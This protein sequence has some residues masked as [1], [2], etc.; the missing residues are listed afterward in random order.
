[1]ADQPTRVTV[2]SAVTTA[3]VTSA[4][5]LL[6]AAAAI[7]AFADD[8]GNGHTN[9]GHTNNGKHYGQTKDDSSDQSNGQTNGQSKGQAKGQS[10]GHAKGQST[11]NG[12]G[13]SG[14]NASANASSQNSTA[15]DDPAGNNGTVKI[16]DVYG[17]TAHHNVPHV[18]CDFAVAF[19]GFDAGQQ[20]DVS[21]AGQA[22][23]GKD[24]PLTVTGASTSIT[25]PDAAGGGQDYDGE[26][27][28]TADQL[29][30]SA[31][32][33]PHPQ[34]GYHIKLTVN[35]YE[36]GGHKYKVFWLQPCTAP[37][38]TTQSGTTTE[39]PTTVLGQNETKQS[40]QSPAEAGT[41]TSAAS[42]TS[43]AAAGIPTEVLGEHI[44]RSSSPAAA[45]APSAATLPFTGAEIGGMTAAAALALG[46]GAALTVAGRRR[47]RTAGSVSES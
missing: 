12:H 25:S 32:G 43:A 18:D 9:N 2:R 47:R 1:M 39:T 5:F 28:F 38:D 37:A 41:E 20:L 17:D 35:T 24:T 45:V 34:Q 40:G 14:S 4:A 3:G 15:S 33:A 44:T 13:Q 36:P 23:T 11:N 21:F 30:L 26:L 42:G 6:A 16:H 19:W 46:A 27:Q 10:K 22:P 29:N 8:G 31:L 7:P